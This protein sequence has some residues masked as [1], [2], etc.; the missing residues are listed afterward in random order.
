MILKSMTQ[1]MLSIWREA[2]AAPNCNNWHASLNAL[3]HSTPSFSV[4]PRTA[5]VIGGMDLR[6]GCSEIFG[7]SGASY[8]LSLAFNL[9][10]L[11]ISR[12]YKLLWQL[13]FP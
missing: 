9:S 1:R 13:I 3:L 10:F 8:K 11:S 6:G 12:V 2:F 4:L 5:A 7:R